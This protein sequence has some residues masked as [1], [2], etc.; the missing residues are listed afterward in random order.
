LSVGRLAPNKAHEQTIAAIFVAR[1]TSDP[2]ARLLLVGSPSQPAYARALH[3]YVAALGLTDSIEFVSDITDAELA[4][5]YRYADLLVMLSDH[6][7]FGVPLVE[8]MREGLPIVAYDAGAVRETLDGAG[9]LLTEKHPRYV[10]AEVSRLMA[11]PEEQRR[12]VAAGRARFEGLGLDNA[13]EALVEAVR[14]VAGRTG[15]I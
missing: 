10:A 6:E 3:R 1:A 4:A 2:D 11:D 14:G 15:A 8:A 12:L 9:V 5:Y 7:G 13:A